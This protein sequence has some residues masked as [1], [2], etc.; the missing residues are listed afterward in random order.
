MAVHMKELSSIRSITAA[1]DVSFTVTE[2]LENVAP[3][4][5]ASRPSITPSPTHSAQ[6]G[7][8][9][10]KYKVLPV[11]FWPVNVMTA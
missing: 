11:G 2:R 10:N 4:W 8:S 5:L 7:K 1:M 9:D 6:F 3:V